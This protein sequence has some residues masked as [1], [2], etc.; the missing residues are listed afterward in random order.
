[1]CHPDPKEKKAEKLEISRAMTCSEKY[2]KAWYDKLGDMFK[3]NNIPSP[4]SNL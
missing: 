3:E 4:N 1:M 2:L